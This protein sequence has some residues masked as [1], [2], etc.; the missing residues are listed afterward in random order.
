[1]G[2][3]VCA[4]KAMQVWFRSLLRLYAILF[5]C[6]AAEAERYTVAQIVP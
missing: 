4:N 3:H 5:D 1:M 6:L 2:L